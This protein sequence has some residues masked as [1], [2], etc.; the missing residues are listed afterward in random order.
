[1]KPRQIQKT[2]ADA[3]IEALLREVLPSSGDGEARM[4]TRLRLVIVV[5]VVAR[6]PKDLFVFL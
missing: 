4:M 5:I 2:W 6:W 3:A 1:V